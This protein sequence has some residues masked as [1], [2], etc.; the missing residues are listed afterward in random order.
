MRYLRDMSIAGLCRDCVRAVSADERRCPACGGPR[1]VR[2]AELETLSLAHIDC[3]AF[4]ASIEKRDNPALADQ[5]VIVGGEKRGVVAAA[6]YIAR[7]YG[8]RSAMPVF[9]ARQLCPDVVAV[10]PNMAKYVSESKKVRELMEAV[11]PLVE[12]ISID[13]AFLDL[14]G[15]QTLHGRSPAQTLAALQTRIETE[16]GVTVS[17]GL[18]FVKFLA[19]IASDLDKPRGF[20]VIGR[21]EAT[22]FL[23]DKPVTILPGV[24]PAFAAALAKDG[25]IKI[26]DIA[27]FDD[28]RLAKHFGEQGLRI[29]KLARAEDP[30]PVS[31]GGAR[32][33]VSS[34]TTFNTDISAYDALDREL[35]RQCVR[36]ADRAKAVN[37]AGRVVT[38]KLKTADHRILSRQRA[39]SAPTQ[40]AD[41][42]FREARELLA[43]EADGRHF[44]L[45][46][47]GISVLEPAGEDAGDLLDPDALKRAAAERA[48]DALRAKFGTDAVIKGRALSASDKPNGQTDDEPR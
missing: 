23:A 12:P 16:V 8:V 34:E 5:P 25:V 6:C 32:K 44:R 33:S 17:I 21:A 18:S 9:K 29:A 10:K 1:L 11:T 43:R 4:Y 27:R 36:V 35:W 39:L 22:A 13:E 7:A 37:V 30:R 31:S 15:T 38:L 46:G 47:V 3:D 28:A 26:G 41:R 24:G 40:L 48:S 2:H 42:M 20:A 19:K 14:A 45:I